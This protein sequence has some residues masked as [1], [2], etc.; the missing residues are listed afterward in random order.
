MVAIIFDLDGVLVNSMPSHVKAWQ[1][2]FKEI[3]GLDVNERDV[4]ILEGMRGMELIQKILGRE[5]EELVRKIQIEK[6]RVF[7]SIRSSS[8]FEG[9]REMLERTAG[10]R[11]VV[12]GSSRQDVQTILKDAFGDT[13]FSAIITADDIKRGKPD[14]SAFLEAAAQ[15][16]VRHADIIVVENA[17]LGAIAASNAKMQCYIAL[18][19]TP[20]VK[21][22]FEEAVT[23]DRIF[24][25]T[26]SVLKHL[27][28]ERR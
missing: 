6:D 7:R 9:V 10:T 11:A 1:R 18:N 22:D 5:D 19:N 8:P 2:S 20:L 24:D 14:P 15:L 16:G 27:E 25:S 23:P 13:I 28:Q 4:Y 12:S 21:K 26:L 17:P 3:A